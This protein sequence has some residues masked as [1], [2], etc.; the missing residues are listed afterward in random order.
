MQ[1]FPNLFNYSALFSRKFPWEHSLGNDVPRCPTL[2]HVSVI[3]SPESQREMAHCITIHKVRGVA[4]QYR[5]C[6]AIKN[7]QMFRIL[8]IFFEIKYH[9]LWWKFKVPKLSSLIVFLMGRFLF[10]GNPHEEDRHIGKLG[11]LPL[12]QQNTEMFLEI[13]LNTIFP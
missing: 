13:F 6:L 4:V 10:C 3:S 2:P 12:D 7:N 1:Q 11:L 9:S 5:C 8:L